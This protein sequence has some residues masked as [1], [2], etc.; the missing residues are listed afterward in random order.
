[1]NE[2]KFFVIT[3]T[4]YFEPSLGC[5][6]KAYEELMD[7]EQKC[8]AETAA[9]DR[10]AFNY[11]KA[12]KRADIVLIA[13][14]LSFNGEKESHKSFGRLLKELQDSGKKIYVVTAGHDFNDHPFAFDETGWIEPEG[15][16]FEELYDFYKDY[17]YSSAIA[18]NKEHL[19]YVTQLADGVRLLVLCNDTAEGKANGFDDEFL[20]WVQAQA[21]KAKEDGQMMI[22]MEH[23]PLLPGQP[24]FSLI[25]DATQK[26][27]KKLA[28]I[29]ADN[30]VHL[31]FTGHMHNQSVNVHITDQG[32][33]IWD[34]CTGSVI[35]HPAFMRLVTVKSENEVDIESIPVPEFEWD[36]KGKTGRQYMQD[37]FERMIRTMLGS[38]VNDPLRLM[39]KVRLGDNKIVEKLVSV[40]GKAVNGWSVGKVA[41][42]LFIKIDPSV[43]DIPFAEL[44]IDLVRSIF[45]GDQPFT[46]GTPKGD[47]V[48]GLFKKLRPILNKINIKTT[49]GEQADLYE[50]LKHTVGNYGISDNNCSL[51][52]Q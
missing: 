6:G 26:N 44:A 12:D 35:G 10:A 42:L 15:T 16:K 49:W 51:R 17:G 40:L 36:K 39:H 22:A 20:A 14:D 48:M 46:E 19:S 8:F 1:M 4:H 31:I 28:K 32:N 27:G 23:Y 7:F 25:G 11:L 50:I 34:V 45:E 41:R 29:L 5:S 2:L 9:I 37:Q 21:S 3:D 52:L 30:G 18:F 43:K 13:G 33:K 24:L 47:A 38:M